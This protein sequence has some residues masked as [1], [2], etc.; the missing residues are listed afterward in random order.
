MIP[1]LILTLALFQQPQTVALVLGPEPARVEIITLVEAENEYA[2][3]SKQPSLTE[4]EN[5][6]LNAL[7]PALGTVP[8]NEQEAA[9]LMDTTRGRACH[10]QRLAGLL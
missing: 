7:V 5:R 1:E 3:L 4:D 6:R 9:G 10:A 2:A 8:C